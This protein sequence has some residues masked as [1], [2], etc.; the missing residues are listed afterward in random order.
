M[1][2]PITLGVEM[3]NIIE[4]KDVVKKYGDKVAVDHLTMSVKQ[5][6]IFGFL[7]PNGAG[8][9]TT[10]RIVSTLTDFSEG[11]VTVKGYDILKDPKAAKSVM[12]VIQQHISLDKDLTVRENM[13]HHAMMHKVPA[14]DREKRIRELCDYIGFNEYID[15]MIDTLSGGWKK[16][17][18][19]MCS[20]IH[21]PELLFLDE[22][23]VGLDVKTRRLLWD[24]IRKLNQNGTTIFLTSHYIEEIETLC[25]RVGIIVQGKL[26]ALGTPGELS[27][28]VGISTVEVHRA[29][30]STEYAHFDDRDKARDYAAGITDAESTLVRN[31]SLEDCFVELTGKT[32]G[33]E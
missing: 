23:T 25:D 13:L 15:K 12:G 17:A 27:K 18:A 31:T 21:Q 19:I 5:G 26:I 30:G 14:K 29:D 16:K 22:P 2:I 8:K 1:C 24:L 28:T 6:E 9:T 11:N 32:V 33:G 7:G 4:L 3:N 20:L 10:V